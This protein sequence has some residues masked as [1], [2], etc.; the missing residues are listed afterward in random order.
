MTPPEPAAEPPRAELAG[1]D[2]FVRARIAERVAD[3]TRPAEGRKYFARLGFQLD[4]ILAHADRG[5][6]ERLTAARQ[7]FSQTALLWAG[8][9]EHPEQP[10]LTDLLDQRPGAARPPEDAPDRSG[11][12]ED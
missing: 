5:P 2:A 3:P 4:Q 1:L 10:D 11:P 7:L 6:A 12:V 9:P 8:H